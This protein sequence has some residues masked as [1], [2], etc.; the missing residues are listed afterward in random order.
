M[1]SLA[2]IAEKYTSPLA[3]TL[4]KWSDM[5]RKSR[6]T[7][8]KI[9]PKNVRPWIDFIPTIFPWRQPL[10][11]NMTT[12]FNNTMAGTCY[13]A[14]TADRK[15]NF[16]QRFTFHLT[17]KCWSRDNNDCPKWDN[18]NSGYKIVNI[19]MPEHVWEEINNLLWLPY[20]YFIVL[21][22]ASVFT[23]K[24]RQRCY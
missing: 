8:K 10:I 21:G 22:G 14:C 2:A 4:L 18:R 16:M 20:V 1:P 24:F 12:V 19:K 13:F 7:D 6:K 5:A 9:Q 15:R 11:V 3:M 17:S 23:N